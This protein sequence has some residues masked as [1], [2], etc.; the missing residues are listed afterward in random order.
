MHHVSPF[1][2]NP[3]QMTFS[4]Y[5]MRNERR[6]RIYKNKRNKV[7]MKKAREKVIFFEI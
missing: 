4:K 3:I 5:E 2:W 1:A 7:E 6:K